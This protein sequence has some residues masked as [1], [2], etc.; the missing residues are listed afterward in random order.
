MSAVFFDDFLKFGTIISRKANR[1][2]IGWGRRHW[3]ENITP[4]Q[5]IC[6]YFPDFF[7]SIKKPWFVHQYV[8][9]ISIDELIKGL[10]L[11]EEQYSAKLTWNN[12]GKTLFSHAFHDLKKNFASHSLKKGV[13]FVFETAVDTLHSN[14]LRH[15]LKSILRYAKKNP[16]YLYG[17]WD[18]EKGMLGATPELLF[19]LNGEG[20]K[21]LACAATCPVGDV[22][23]MVNDPKQLHEHHLVVQGMTESLSPLGK[24]SKG[25]LKVLTLP[26]LCHLITSIDVE[27]RNPVDF[28]SLVS[29]LHPTP[30][31]GAIPKKAGMRWLRDYQTK[32]PRHRFGAPS[33]YFS[34]E[35]NEAACYVAIRNI[36]WS[37][38]QMN[39]GAGC[40]I[41]PASH[42]DVEWEE[43]QLK[44]Q[45]IKDMLAL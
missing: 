10:A 44:I 29:A 28:S 37:K 9:E 41:V 32:I 30:A 11:P 45:A 8:A 22:F 39:I 40:G 31:L 34:N 25:D 26:N 20:V 15:A 36:Q 14:R 19:S 27:M 18:H 4:N 3:I 23:S 42:L 13:P 21:T 5:D 6:F 38:D 17:F 33:G 43:I 24:V 1:L 16:V 7:L 12:S 35:Q 2:L